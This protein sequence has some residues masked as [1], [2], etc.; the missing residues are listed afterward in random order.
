MYCLATL[1]LILEQLKSAPVISP[2]PQ[3]PFPFESVLTASATS[4]KQDRPGAGLLEL[5]I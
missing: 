3:K 1:T 2:P 4:D 5:A